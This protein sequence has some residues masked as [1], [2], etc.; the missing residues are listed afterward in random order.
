MSTRTGHRVLLILAF[1]IGSGGIVR[2]AMNPDMGCAAEWIFYI[3][4]EICFYLPVFLAW[5]ELLITKHRRYSYQAGSH[6]DSTHTGG[7]RTWLLL[8]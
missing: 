8:L 7:T 6:I 4:V 5:R 1:S 2:A 3:M